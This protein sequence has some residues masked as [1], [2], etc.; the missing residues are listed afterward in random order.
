MC[1]LSL[2]AGA[3]LVHIS[4]VLLHPSLRS[5]VIHIDRASRVCVSVRRMIDCSLSELHRVMHRQIVFESS[6]EHSVR[7]GRSRSNGE[8]L[9][10][11]SCSIIIV[12]EQLWSMSLI[13]S[14]DHRA[15]GQAAT[16]VLIENVS[17][18]LRSRCD[19]DALAFT[20]LVDLRER[21]AKGERE[22][23]TRN[24]E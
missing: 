13:P 18:N 23:D 7:V 3:D 5:D 12:I 11:Q 2:S 14:S 8:S 17:Q 15:D 1:A 16:A 10:L 22:K 24:E 9:S 19:A 20:K 6:V 4:L 21:E